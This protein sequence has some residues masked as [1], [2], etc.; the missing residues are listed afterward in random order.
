MKNQYKRSDSYLHL[1][2]FPDTNV[3]EKYGASAGA[4]MRRC[5]HAAGG[6]ARVR[7]AQQVR[8]ADF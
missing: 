1:H 5:T 8:R 3:N 2:F 6:M 7:S 4:Y